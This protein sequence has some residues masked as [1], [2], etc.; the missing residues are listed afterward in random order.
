M[1]TVNK[2]YLLHGWSDSTQKW[3]TLV[4]LLEK[5]GFKV[6]L[7][8]IPGLTEPLKEEWKLED[9][10]S[11]LKNLLENE[12]K[13]ILVGHSNGGRISLAF[14]LKYP[15][16]VEHLVLIDSAGV[17][18]NHR[19]LRFKRF[20]FKTLAFAGKKIT[21]SERLRNV[22]YKLAR[23]KD[24]QQADP[25]LR[26]TLTNLIKIDLVPHLTNLKVATLIIWGEND[27]ATPLQD[28]L[29][30]HQKITNSVLKIIPEARHSPQFTHP[31]TVA[32]L[33]AEGVK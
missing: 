6:H 33:I 15:E 32:K 18:H 2:I 11:W 26:K 8:R 12:N 23:E 20:L 13:V 14:S 30:M 21:R 3:G 9:Y 4:N 28:G 29:L 7:P 10:V 27:K 25:I 31:D 17:Y 19:G 16:K 22:L 1:G 5:R 24:Y